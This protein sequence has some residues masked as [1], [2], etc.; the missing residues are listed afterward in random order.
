MDNR[1]RTGEFSKSCRTHDIIRSSSAL[2]WDRPHTPAKSPHQARRFV[3][4]THGEIRE[5][6]TMDMGGIRF[7]DALWSDF[8]DS[9]LVHIYGEKVC[10]LIQSR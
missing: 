4:F 3:N 10:F 5:L 9:V 2:Y 1:Y 8:R 7:H 6:E